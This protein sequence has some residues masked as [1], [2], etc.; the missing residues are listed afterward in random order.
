VRGGDHARKAAQSV[1]GPGLLLRGSFAWRSLLLREAAV[2]R[3][4]SSRF[5]G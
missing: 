1:L 3:S 5:V 2:R 4:A